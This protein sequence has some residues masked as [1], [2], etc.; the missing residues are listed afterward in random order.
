MMPFM[1]LSHFNLKSPPFSITSDPSFVFFSK[2]HR[3]AFNHLLF[4]VRNRLGFIEITG[5]IGCGKTGGNSAFL[6]FDCGWTGLMVDATTSKV[7]SLRRALCRICANS[8][9]SSRTRC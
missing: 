7:A 5:E 3:E 2:R 6:A 1:Y 4:G 8:S 9:S